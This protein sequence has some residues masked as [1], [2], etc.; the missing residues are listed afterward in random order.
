MP[1]PRLNPNLIINPDWLDR[2]KWRLGIPADFWIILE[3]LIEQ[4]IKEKELQPVPETRFSSLVNPVARDTEVLASSRMINIE[5]IIGIYG[6]RKIPHLHYK[7]DLYLLDRESWQ[8][9]STTVMKEFAEQLA[10]SNSIP[11]E[12]FMEMADNLD[13]NIL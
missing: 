5:N 9:F 6:G 2:W 11:F 3:P 1:S 7:G 8:E 12:S 4:F 10:Q 13:R